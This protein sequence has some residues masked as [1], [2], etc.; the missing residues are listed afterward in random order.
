MAWTGPAICKDCFEVGHEVPDAFIQHYP[1]AAPA[2]RPHHEKYLG[3]L[4]QI[5]ELILNQQGV[6]AIYHADACTL[7]QEN[8]FYSYR[9]TP[10]TGRMTTLIWFNQTMDDL[11]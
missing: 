2:F 9:R 10:Q 5:A 7:E 1:S 8:R 11:G 3:D 4:P 6:H